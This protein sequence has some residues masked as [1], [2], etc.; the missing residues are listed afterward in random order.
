MNEEQVAKDRANAG[1]PCG[2]ATVN[3]TSRGSAGPLIEFN[4]SKFS[5]AVNTKI[6]RMFG[7][8][9]Y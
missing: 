6:E 5:T 9:Y 4:I 1:Y 8:T 7:K 3:V 2:Q